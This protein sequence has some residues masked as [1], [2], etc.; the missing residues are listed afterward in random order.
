M[1]ITPIRH[2]WPV[3]VDESILERLLSERRDGRGFR[4][5]RQRHGDE[6]EPSFDGRQ[7]HLPKTVR[8]RTEERGEMVSKERQREPMRTEDI[9]HEEAETTTPPGS[10]LERSGG[11]AGAVGLADQASKTTLEATSQVNAKWEE[12]EEHMADT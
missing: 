8:R 11:G 2:V 12:E 1:I 10:G 4:S 5:Q 6:E 7:R 9:K 3:S